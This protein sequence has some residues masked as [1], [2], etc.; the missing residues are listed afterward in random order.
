MGIQQMKGALDMAKPKGTKNKTLEEKIADKELEV[1]KA[2]ETYNKLRSELNL[3][4][5]ELEN[6]ENELVIKAMR[7]KGIQAA[8]LLSMIEKMEPA[9]AEESET[10]Q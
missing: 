6:R 9:A 7:E 5:K 2:K 4:K 1:Q 10:A 3:M 8:D